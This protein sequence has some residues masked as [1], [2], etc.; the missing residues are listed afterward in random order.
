LALSGNLITTSMGGSITD[1]GA[2]AISGTSLFTTNASNKN[3]TLDTINNAFAGA[4]T[5]STTGSTGNATVDGG[6]T[7][8]DIAASTV[9]G[10]LSL[11]SGHAT[12]ITDS[13]IITVGGNLIATNDVSNGDINMG[14]LAVD[15]TIAVTTTGSGGDV[16]LVN[17][18]G[19]DF[20]TSN[21]GGDLN[22]TATTGD[23]S[24]S[25]T[26]R[27]TGVTEMTMGTSP[28]KIVIGKTSVTVDDDEMT[29]DNSVFTGG[30]S[31]NYEGQLVI[32]VDEDDSN[33]DVDLAGQVTFVDLTGG[34][35]Q[36]N[37]TNNLHR[38]SSGY[39]SRKEV[40]STSEQKD[41]IEDT[42]REL[43]DAAEQKDKEEGEEE[44][45]ED[46]EEEDEEENNEF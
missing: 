19:L 38:L 6:T 41:K 15:G 25:G 33:V 45:E 8:L 7:Q 18:E 13:G 5:L 39:S 2:L 23:I 22:A 11:T 29:L 12:G 21:I 32:I 4:V 35:D 36:M 42:S 17:D 24:D 31:L 40:K 14:S 34:I 9:G 28:T 37:F 26:L 3:I 10:N 44:D 30:I 16:I 27:V 46:D 1:S 20:A 43:K